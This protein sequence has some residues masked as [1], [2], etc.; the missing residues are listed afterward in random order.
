MSPDMKRHAAFSVRFASKSRL[1]HPAIKLAWLL[2]T[3]LLIGVTL[4][5][6]SLTPKVD[7][8]FFF[9]ADD[10]QKLKSR[11][12]LDPALFRSSSNPR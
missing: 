10:P 8:S 6:V 4:R 9:G 7:E 11:L 5:T 2:V 1:A 12:R 3:G